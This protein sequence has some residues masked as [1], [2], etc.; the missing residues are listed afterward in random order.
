MATSMC[1]FDGCERPHSAR[2]YCASHYRQWRR[3]PGALTADF[4]VWTDTTVRDEQSRKRCKTCESWKPETEYTKVHTSADGF[5]WTCRACRTKHRRDVGYNLAPG[6]FDEM[7][8][9]QGG[10]C[11]ICRTD[12][13]GKYNWSVDHDHTCCPGKRQSCGKCVRGLLCSRCNFGIG[14]FL[15]NAEAMRA[16]ADYVDSYRVRLAA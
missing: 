7:L 15:D 16:A 13:P 12:A 11:A 6:Q 2:G 1:A 8:R 5:H 4:K 9:A 3:D 10:R 14:H